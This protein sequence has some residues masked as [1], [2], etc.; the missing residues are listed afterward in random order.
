M[1]SRA[2]DRMEAH[3]ASLRTLDTTQFAQLAALHLRAQRGGSINEAAAV[4]NLSPR[5]YSLIRPHP[6][7]RRYA[8]LA[9]S[10]H[11]IGSAL[12]VSGKISSSLA[13]NQ[14]V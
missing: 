11:T 9:A 6:V 10:L 3:I 13:I 1:W 8:K 14:G 5:A 7:A 12:S 4:A 2:V